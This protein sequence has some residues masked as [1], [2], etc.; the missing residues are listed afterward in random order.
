VL[1]L[2]L[3]ELVAAGLPVVLLLTVVDEDAL[4][5]FGTGF[6]WFETVLAGVLVTV[7]RL[8]AVA[9]F[10][11]TDVREGDVVTRVAVA[12]EAE[13]DVPVETLLVATD[14]DLLTLLLVPTPPLVET[15]LVNTRSEPV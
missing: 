4:P 6:L 12:L 9:G 1:E 8:V 5:V 13:A 15:L 2:L 11:L 7:G 10:L 3:Y 14:S